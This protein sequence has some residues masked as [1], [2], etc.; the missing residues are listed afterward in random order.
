M[1]IQPIVKDL[2]HNYYNIPR[3]CHITKKVWNGYLESMHHLCDQYFNAT[4]ITVQYNKI[5][6]AL[7]NK[8]VDKVESIIFFD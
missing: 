7:L 5:D 2:G 4:A 6:A 8:I 3:I 1:N